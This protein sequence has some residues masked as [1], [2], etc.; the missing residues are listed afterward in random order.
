MQPALPDGIRNRPTSSAACRTG[1]RTFLIWFRRQPRLYRLHHF[2]GSHV[3]AKSMTVFEKNGGSPFESHFLGEIVLRRDRR[4]VARCLT[5]NR[6]AALR[7]C[8]SIL[9]IG[10]TPNG[11]HR[12][13]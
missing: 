13:P 12:L 10:R 7:A 9:P 3:S 11:F 6:H 1:D 4:T 2:F 8:Q 5:F